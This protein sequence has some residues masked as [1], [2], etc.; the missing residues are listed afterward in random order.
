[1]PVEAAAVVDDDNAPIGEESDDG[2]GKG[3]RDRQERL[4]RAARLLNQGS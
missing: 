2:D 1:M 4:M 3:L